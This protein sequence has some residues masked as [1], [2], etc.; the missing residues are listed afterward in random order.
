M[1]YP[2]ILLLTT[3]LLLL[4]LMPCTSTA[5]RFN[6]VVDRSLY[7]DKQA[8]HEGDIVTILLYEVTEG[9]NSTETSTLSDNELDASLGTGGLMDQML[10]PFNA[11]S[12]LRNRN[13]SEGN[14]ATQGKLVGK[15]TA[16][17]TEVQ[18]TGLLSIRGTRIVNMNG[19]KQET[20]ITGMIRPE[21]VRPDNT[22]YSYQVAEAN[23]SYT[24]KG[25]ATE[26]GKP[27]VLV[28][29]WNWLF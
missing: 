9:S 11:S 2:A 8:F 28:R 10:R 27:G 7:C 25:V 15:V 22:I 26:A 16:I 6:N 18:D 4:L 13:D 5:Q 12:T 17:V 23:I 19:E 1:K 29:M 3:M 24:G 21:D 14:I 20:T